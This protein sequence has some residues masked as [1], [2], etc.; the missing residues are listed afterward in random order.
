L[1]YPLYLNLPKTHHHHHHPP[2]KN[3]QNKI[4]NPSSVSSGGA[5]L[6]R[7]PALKHPERVQNKLY[8]MLSREPTQKKKNSQL[9]FSISGPLKIALQKKTKTP[10]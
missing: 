5:V 2:Q 4:K 3:K 6:Q 9:S 8:K 10:S 7:C 1:K